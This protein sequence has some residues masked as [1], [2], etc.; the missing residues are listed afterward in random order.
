MITNYHTVFTV[1]IIS[2]FLPFLTSIVLLR[3]LKAEKTLRLCWFFFAFAAITEIVLYI[4]SS[5]NKQ[6]A[7]IFHIYTFLEYVLITMILANWQNKSSIA[8]L[9]RISIPIY[10]F[11]FILI[12]TVGL[13]SFETGLYNNITRPLALLLLST[14]AFLALQ[15]LWSQTPA[16]LTNDYRFWMLLAMALYYSA[17]LALFAFMFTKDQNLLIALFKIHAVVNIM[18]NIL[19]TIGVLRLRGAKQ[20]TLQPASAS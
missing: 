5:K 14:F 12:K 3:Y 13:E 2:T 20:K 1:S 4:F 8:K 17:S 7:W 19:F 16:N 10:I 9:V 15:N 18:R 6:S 11:F